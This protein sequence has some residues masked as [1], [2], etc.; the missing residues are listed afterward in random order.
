MPDPQKEGASS[1]ATLDAPSGIQAL[2]ARVARF[3]AARKRALDLSEY[4][5]AVCPRMYPNSAA[6]RAWKA[7]LDGL[8]GCGEYLLFRHYPAVDTVRLH[9]AQFCK[10]HLLCPLCAIRRG[11]KALASYLERYEVVRAANGALRP[12][13]VTL[14]VKDGPDLGERFQH[15]RGHFQK[16]GKRRGHPKYVRSQWYGIAGAVWSYEVKRGRNS[17]E[18]HPHVHAIVLAEQAPDADLLATEWQELTKDSFIVDVR[19]IDM[20]D[21]AGGFAEVFKYAV[22]FS[23]MEPADA[24]HAFEVLRGARLIGSSGCLFDVDVPEDLTDAPL[25]GLPYVE[26]L[27]RYLRGSGYTWCSD[28]PTRPDVPLRPPRPARAV[29][30]VMQDGLYGRRRFARLDANGFDLIHGHVP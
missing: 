21:P 13:L 12:F 30:W 14:T 17:G 4:I 18:W 8:E 29:R 1:A 7:V 22:K 24:V 27:Y 25:D 16:L 20:A 11:S 9:A 28:M 3:E 15:L 2:P 10:R 23:D 19:P 6:Y 26:L 5:R